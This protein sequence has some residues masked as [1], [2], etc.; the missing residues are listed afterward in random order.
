[1]EGLF[2]LMIWRVSVCNPLA[3]LP[4]PEA[5]WYASPHYMLEKAAH[6]VE[7]RK[8]KEK[9]GTRVQYPFQSQ[10]SRGLISNQAQL[11]KALPPLN[12]IMTSG[13]SP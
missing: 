13:V 6:L 11:S 1:M 5:S 9:E 8:P 10:A 2:G 12:R 3:W 7:G 4:E